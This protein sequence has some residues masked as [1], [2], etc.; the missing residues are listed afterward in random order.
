[1][2]KTKLITGLSVLTIALLGTGYAYWSDSFSVKTTVTTGVLDVE[3]SQTEGQE[4]AYYYT[5]FRDIFGNDESGKI[6]DVSHYFGEAIK[7]M[8][9]TLINDKENGNGTVLTINIEE[10]HPGV[11]FEFPFTVKDHTTIPTVCTV[12]GAFEDEV[13]D[14]LTGFIVNL[15]KENGSPV[16]EVVYVGSDMT[17][18][19]HT[20]LEN[21]FKTLFEEDALVGVGDNEIDGDYWL[22]IYMNSELTT[23]QNQTL[24]PYTVS[25][26]WQQINA[27]TPAIQP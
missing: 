7:K 26:D 1:M 27:V 11:S 22:D 5:E 12:T 16:K 20:H 21:A 18:P 4:A 15:Y 19:V 17:V 23:G 6:S 9:A 25:I 3:I 24:K 14:A 13:G 2:K 10:M 8:D